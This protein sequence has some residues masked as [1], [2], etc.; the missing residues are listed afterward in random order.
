MS[1][2]PR[3]AGGPS[4][5]RGGHGLVSRGLALALLAIVY[6]L[7]LASFD[8]LDIA[9]ALLISAATLAGLRRFLLTGPPLAA[10]EVARRAIHLPAFAL[11]VTWEVVAGTWHVALI[12]SGVRPLTRPGIIELPIG[13]RTPNGVAVSALAISLSPGELVIDVDWP[14]RVMLVHVI[15]ATDPDGIREHQARFYE[16]FQRGVFP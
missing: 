6:L 16:R 9:A 3:S 4:K 11:A 2:G 15:D 1:A 8:P 12:V 14:R 5:R 10:R 7:T 13:E